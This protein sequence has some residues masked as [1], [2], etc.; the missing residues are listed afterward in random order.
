MKK[1]KYIQFLAF[2]GVLFVNSCSKDWLEV[3]PTGKIEPGTYYNTDQEIQNA[4]ISIYDCISSLDQNNNGW[5]SNFIMRNL[6]GDD[7][8]CG[9]GGASDQAQY[10]AIDDFNWTPSNQGIANFW[11]N[12]YFGIYRSNLVIENVKSTSTL[13]KRSIAEAKFFRAYFYLDL[14]MC[15]GDVPLYTTSSKSLSD[16][17]VRAPQAEVYT[18]IVKDLNEA[19]TDLSNKNDYS[20]TE[21]FRVSKQ[22]AQAL[23]G[24][25]YL[26]QKN[27]SAAVTAFESV[28][29]TE[30]TQVGLYPNFE[31]LTKQVSEF[32][33]E[34]LLE[35]DF[36]NEGKDWGNVQWNR[37]ANDNRHIQLCGPRSDLG[38]TIGIRPGWGFLPPTA[39]LY[40]M[41]SAADP[42][43]Q[44]TI[45]SN[46][47]LAAFGSSFADGW[48]TE[49]MV[50]RKYTT[51]ATETTGANGATPELNFG[52]NWRL[53]RYADVL[54]MAA[55]AY[56][57][58]GDENSAR[59][60]INK[61]RARVGYTSTTATGTALLDVIKYERMIELAYEGTRFWDLVRWGDAATEL[62]SLGFV[63]G[64]HEHFPIPEQEI[65]GG[66]ATQ[67]PGY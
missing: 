38:G 26:Y 31:D 47:D 6:P 14:V 13:A 63:A 7:V 60:Q 44:Y 58:A 18:Q 42:R 11:S 32:G 40:N 55:E 5:S 66:K 17:G 54:L 9:G 22:A 62:T 1:Y 24:K 25:A 3:K 57:M 52:T 10:Q 21:K 34:S 43:K 8:N 46:A 35:A 49:G 27:W 61:V 59:T 65:N 33:I 48:D 19:I 41:I 2:A 51:F 4:V 16:Y 50:R 12:D 67:N 23:L 30:G 56:Y 64:K 15:F 53:I 39:K 28:I 29:A 20:V 36:I 45:L 37:I